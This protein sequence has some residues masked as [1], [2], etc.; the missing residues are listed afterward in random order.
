M[1]KSS[2]SDCVRGITWIWTRVGRCV[3]PSSRC[4]KLTLAESQ[5]FYEIHQSL[6]HQ[7]V[8]IDSEGKLLKNCDICCNMKIPGFKPN[9]NFLILLFSK[10]PAFSLPS[11]TISH[12]LVHIKGKTSFWVFIIMKNCQC[13]WRCS[14]S[15]EFLCYFYGIIEINILFKSKITVSPS[16]AVDRFLSGTYII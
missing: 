7:N 3:V 1:K 8:V 16:T 12:S 11:K 2:F 9:K 5:W 13:L 4:W 15:T 10:L 6:T 14:H